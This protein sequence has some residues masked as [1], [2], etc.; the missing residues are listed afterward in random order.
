MVQNCIYLLLLRIKSQLD[1]V[2]IEETRK[3]AH[4]RIHVEHTIGLLRQTMHY[5][6]ENSTDRLFDV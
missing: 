5:F 4:V 1:P 3:I 6:T 2:G